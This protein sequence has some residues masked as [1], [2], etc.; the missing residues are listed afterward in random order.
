MKEFTHLAC[1]LC[2]AD[3]DNTWIVWRNTHGQTT[4]IRKHL[5]SQHGRYCW[6]MVVLK[7]LKGWETVGQAKGSS[8]GAEREPFSL[9][10]FYERLVRWIAVDDQSLD[11]VDCPEL[12]DLLLFIGAELEDR[13]IPHRTKL[14]ELVSQRFKYEWTRMV[15]DM[16]NS[17]GRVSATDDIWSRMNLESYM[18]ISLHYSA[19]DAKGNLVLKSQLVAFR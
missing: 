13:D 10:G 17:L 19:K 1:R 8:E 18:A 7:Q 16:A 6:E 9:P 5:Q 12:R 15:E 2:P 11:V 3:S 14:S 4:T